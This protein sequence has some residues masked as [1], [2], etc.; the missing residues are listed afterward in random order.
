[1]AELLRNARP[2]AKKMAMRCFFNR[3][4]DF[5][6]L[7]LWCTGEEC[8]SGGAFGACLRAGPFAALWR[9]RYGE[10]D[11]TKSPAL[12]LAVSEASK[13][14]LIFFSDDSSTPLLSHAAIRASP[15]SA[16]QS[17]VTERSSCASQA[18]MIALES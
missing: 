17:G 9:D 13:H 14:G 18:Q 16:G 10:D 7:R 2:L 3:G 1:M 11:V 8:I 4:Y 12:A 6:V 5:V 15:R